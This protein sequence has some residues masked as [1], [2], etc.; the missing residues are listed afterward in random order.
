MSELLLPNFVLSKLDRIIRENGFINY[1]MEVMP[2]S[3]IG[4]GFTSQLARIKISESGCDNTL[5]IMCKLAPLTD[6]PA[7]KSK[8]YFIFRR[9]ATFYTE[10]MPK[11]AKFQ[12]EKNLSKS[13]QFLAYPK[14]YGTIIDDENGDY[15]II[16]EDLRPQ[17]FKLWP[18]VKTSPIENIRLAMREIG[19]FHGLS[20]A[21]KD[22]RP[23]E[24]SEFEQFTDLYK[25]LF[26]SK[27][28]PDMFRNS[29]DYAIKS[30]KCENYKKIMREIRENFLEY[31]DA[32]LNEKSSSYFGV[33]CH[34]DFWNNNILYKFNKNDAAEDIRILDWQVL[35][36]GSPAI[37]LITNIFTTTDKTMRDKEYDNF[38]RIYYESFSNTVKLLGSNPNELFT[39]DDLQ[40][41]LKR[42]GVYTLLL[43]PIAIQVSQADERELTDR[44]DANAKGIVGQLSERGQQEYERRLN[45]VFEDVIRFGYY[46]QN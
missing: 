25:V 4:D 39:F 11:F 26:K 2:G 18:K 9:E 13:D 14:C 8:S 16:L 41:E 31:F 1:S 35:R 37:D 45:G 28:V 32:C 10:V 23:Q 12:E 40:S 30:L 21:M 34:G 20:F 38:L 7:R 15:A 5:Q 43:L 3:Q 27:G 42:C 33:I 6:D 24:F 17:E 29:Y 46:Q 19:K 22:Q 44:S 36:Y